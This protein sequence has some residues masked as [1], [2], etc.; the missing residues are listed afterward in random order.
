MFNKFRNCNCFSVII[1]LLLFCSSCNFSH[2]NNKLEGLKTLQQ[3]K[4]EP[5]NL[6]GHWFGEGKKEQFLKE[7][8]NEFEFTNQDV[9][10]NMK[11]P[12]QIY[13]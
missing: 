2:S 12:E 1:C 10:V 13:F 6:I 9:N 5:L 4:A 7:L 11:Y 8:V 3:E